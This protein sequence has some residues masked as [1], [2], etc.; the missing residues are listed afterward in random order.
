MSANIVPRLLAVVEVDRDDRVICQASGCGHSIYKRIHVVRESGRITVIGSECFKRLYGGLPNVPQAPMFGT[1]EGRR[2]SAA[3]RA[4]LLENTAALVAALE[5][6][7]LEAEK[8]KEAAHLEAERE[9]Q[10][11]AAT[12]RLLQLRGRGAYGRSRVPPVIDILAA[13]PTPE[14]ERVR[15]EAKAIVQAENPG[16]NVDAPGWT[17]L[18]E[19]E[20]RKLVRRRR[21]GPA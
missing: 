10:R 7:H 17:G 20:M 5:A 3:E 4:V 11:L 14:L 21:Y 1:G 9:T 15:A 2:L 16:V 8:A 6:E 18:V 12:R 13:V 19:S